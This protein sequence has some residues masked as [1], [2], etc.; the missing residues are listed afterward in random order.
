[1][2]GDVVPEELEVFLE[3]VSSDRS[4]VVAKE[5]GQGID[6]VVG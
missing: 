1:M 5:I 4:Q 2:W 6:L 3:E